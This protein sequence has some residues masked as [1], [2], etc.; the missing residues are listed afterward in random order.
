MTLSSLGKLEAYAR[1]TIYHAKTNEL[2]CDAIVLR[3]SELVPAL[4]VKA[5]PETKCFVMVLLLFVHSGILILSS[6]LHHIASI[7][8]VHA[9]FQE[10]PVSPLSRLG[11]CKSMCG[12]ILCASWCS[13]AGALDRFPFPHGSIGLARLA[14]SCMAD[15]GQQLPE[16]AIFVDAL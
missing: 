11:G 15:Y 1:L 3:E 6:I 12:F 8:N 16:E 13:E 2:L 4:V 5:A 9:C 14:T 10:A 7:V